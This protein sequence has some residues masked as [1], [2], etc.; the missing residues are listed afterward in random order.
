MQPG[1]NKSIIYSNVTFSNYISLKNFEID[2]SYFLKFCLMFIVCVSVDATITKYTILKILCWWKIQK[3][4]WKLTYKEVKERQEKK[5]LTINYK[6][7]WMIV[8]KR[9]N[10]S[11]ELGQINQ[12]QADAEI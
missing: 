2:N 4:N 8:N 9:D 11:C 7:E 10:K 5:R 3:G 1:K 12:N 6:K